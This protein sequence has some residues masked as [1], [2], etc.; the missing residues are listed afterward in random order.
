MYKVTQSPLHE[1]CK[2]E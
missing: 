2:F 1:N